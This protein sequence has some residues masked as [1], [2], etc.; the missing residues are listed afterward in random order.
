MMSK[1]PLVL[2]IDDDEWLTSQYARLIERAGY[3]VHAVT[4]ALDGIEAID[5]LHPSVIILDVFMAGPNGI[6]LLHEIRSHSDLAQIPVV[7]C[8]NSAGDLDEK[9]MAAYGV[10]AILD[11]ATMMPDDIVTSI[12]RVV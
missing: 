11:K 4:H 6:V 5:R 1:R 2:L 8:T 9:T 3:R 10:A 12:R 7:L